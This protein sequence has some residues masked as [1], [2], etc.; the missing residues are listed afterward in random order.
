MLG[1][2]CGQSNQENE[3]LL[4]PKLTFRIYAANSTTIKQSNEL[5]TMLA[6]SQ[7]IAPEILHID[8][9]IFTLL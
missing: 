3:L 5:Q 7:T 6:G 8:V 4:P 2:V 1:C 9:L